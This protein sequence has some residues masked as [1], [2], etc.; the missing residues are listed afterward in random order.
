M[1]QH[2]FKAIRPFST[3]T[4]S[5]LST[6]EVRPTADQATTQNNSL[7]ESLNLTK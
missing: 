1:S 5:I 6:V 3:G 4:L 7:D 2:G